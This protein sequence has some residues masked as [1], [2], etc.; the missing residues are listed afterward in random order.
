MHT[1]SQGIHT[2]ANAHTE[3][4]YTHTQKHRTAGGVRGTHTHKLRQAE[5]TR[6]G[7]HTSIPTSRHTDMYTVSQAY[8][9]TEKAGRQTVNPKFTHSYIQTNM[10]A[11]SQAGIQT[12]IQAYTHTGIHKYIHTYTHTD[13]QSGRY[14]YIHTHT[15]IRMCIQ[16]YR[17]VGIQ[18]TEKMGGAPIRTYIQTYIQA[19]IHTDRQTDRHT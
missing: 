1:G 13:R 12:G 6:P 11:A 19:Y 8:P 9:L 3:N 10:H 5:T 7:I 15:Y 17:E 18:G 2:Q 4:T 14:T 16:L